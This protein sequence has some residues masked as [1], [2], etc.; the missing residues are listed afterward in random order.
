M[1]LAELKADHGIGM[2]WLS[3]RDGRSLANVCGTVLWGGVKKLVTRV[4]RTLIGGS[5]GKVVRRVVGGIVVGGVERF[6]RRVLGRVVS[7][8]GS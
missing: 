6:V 1:K 7:R 5:G 4:V 2:V 3:R 8:G